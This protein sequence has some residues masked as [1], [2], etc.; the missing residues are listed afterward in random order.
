MPQEV[1]DSLAAQV[2]FPHRFGHPHEYAR[3]VMHIVENVMINA[4]SIRLDGAMRM[5]AR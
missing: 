3:L 1:Q 4:A 2:P 5:Q